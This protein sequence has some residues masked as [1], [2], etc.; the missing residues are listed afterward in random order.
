MGEKNLGLAALGTTSSEVALG[1][2]RME[3]RQGRFVI[4]PMLALFIAFAAEHY[5]NINTVTAGD[6]T[7][8]WS[9]GRL[10]LAQPA[11]VLYQ[12]HSIQASRC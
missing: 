5:I 7:A 2:W 12:G 10:M 4:L 6:F 9:Y 3:S 8:L 11:D 1:G